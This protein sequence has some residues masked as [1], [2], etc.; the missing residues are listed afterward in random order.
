MNR[1]G[2]VGAGAWGTSIAMQ[3]I[4]GGNN[5]VIWAREQEVVNSINNE[6]VNSIFLPNIKLDTRITAIAELSE[7]LPVDMI[8]IA[9]PAQHFRETCKKLEQYLLPNIPVIICSK[10]I[11]Q[12][13]NAL[14]NNILSECIPQSSAMIMS[15]P[16]FAGE[17]AEGLPT[18]VTLACEDLKQGNVVS[19]AIA[20]DYFRPYLSTDLIGVAIGGA[21]KNVL[22]IACGML[23]GRQMG[24]NARASLITRGLAEVVRLAVALGGEYKTLNGLSGLGDLLLTA[25]SPQSRNYSLGVAIGKGI[26][27]NDILSKRVSVA[28]G[29][30]TSSALASLASSL[31][32]EMPI[33][34]EVDKVINH[35]KPIDLAIKD[36]V[37]RPIR[38]E[39]D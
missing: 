13:T 9:V 4:R 35:F 12:G 30:F 1:V 8:F 34:F 39:L 2:I 17:V 16:T 36:I 37:G 29:V 15:G 20:T 24:D 31:S 28:E 38:K 5:V 23:E 11:E 25:T 21:V 3:A 26:P 33:C 6:S 10:G 14:M 32:I 19:A 18:A 27:Y 22:A 7:L